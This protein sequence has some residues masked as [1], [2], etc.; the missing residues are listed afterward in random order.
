MNNIAQP[1]GL[2]KIYDL[3]FEGANSGNHEMHVS[4]VAG[5]FLD[6]CEE[7]GNPLL[8][9]EAPH[10]TDHKCAGRKTQGGTQGHGIPRLILRGINP[11]RNNADFGLRQPWVIFQQG[12]FGG[13][14]IHNDGIRKCFEGQPIVPF[15]FDGKVHLVKAND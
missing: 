3:L 15:V 5:N 14:G 4:I 12:P 9:R 6:G 8:P 13:S 11:M 10:K 1:G 2:H 7:H